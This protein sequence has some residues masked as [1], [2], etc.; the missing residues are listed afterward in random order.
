MEQFT[1]GLKT[2]GAL[3]LAGF[4]NDVEKATQALEKSNE[5]LKNNPRII[6]MLA[7]ENNQKQIGE[8]IKY[9][10]SGKGNVFGI[11]SKVQELAS[12]LKI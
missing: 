6:P 5:I 2:F 11:I 12:K 7:D 4:N 10:E 9:V 8:I 3:F 1:N